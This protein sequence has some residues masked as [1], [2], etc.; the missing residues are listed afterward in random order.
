VLLIKVH[1]LNNSRSQRVLWLL[2]EIGLDYEVIRYQRDAKTMLAPS[3]LRRIH[4]LGKA[5]IIEDGSL[6]LAETGA[7]VD[8]LVG[9]YGKELEPAQGS[10]AYCRHRYWLHCAEGSLMPPLL[11]K[12]VVSR[13]GL[14]GWAARRYVDGQIKLHLDYLE[15]ELDNKQWFAG[16][17]FSAADIMMS[18]PLEAVELAGRIERGATEAMELPCSHSCPARLS[19]GAE[20]GRQVRV[21]RRSLGPCERKGRP[22]TITG[23]CVK[24]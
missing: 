8:Y 14:F 23:T 4:P 22:T 24:R 16:D 3:S 19:K 9:Q 18:F 11:L 2:E 21:R 17:E 6:R 15:K 12:L 10:E 7:I 5:P 1:H 20:P 13:L